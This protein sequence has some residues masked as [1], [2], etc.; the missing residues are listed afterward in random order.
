MNGH[1]EQDVP[2]FNDGIVDI[3]GNEASSRQAFF[4]FLLYKNLKP[5]NFD[6]SF[7]FH[8]QTFPHNGIS[9]G[10]R[11]IAQCT[12]ENHFPMAYVTNLNMFS[13]YIVLQE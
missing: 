8:I 6:I 4:W 11:I 1:Q 3:P 12:E 10:G 13:L 9:E 2:I 5:I 7:F